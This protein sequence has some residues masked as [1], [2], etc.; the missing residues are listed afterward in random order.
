MEILAI[1][2]LNSDLVG[3]SG[4]RL[5][6]IGRASAQEA[7]N[8]AGADRN[9]DPPRRIGIVAISFAR[10]NFVPG[11]SSKDLFA[12][13]FEDLAPKGLLATIVPPW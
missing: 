12:N 8:A 4:K 1:S 5:E 3:E 2:E 6:I 7:Q 10:P 11:Q 9:P 13:R